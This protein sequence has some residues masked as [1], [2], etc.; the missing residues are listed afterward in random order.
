MAARWNISNL[1]IETDSTELVE[2]IHKGH[3]CY[4]YIIFEC[5]QLLQRLGTH[6]SA[7]AAG[8]KPGGR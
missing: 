2:V 8:A 6:G 3:D 5:R 1:Q 4:T 7:I